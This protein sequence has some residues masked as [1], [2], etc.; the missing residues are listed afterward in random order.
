MPHGV[1]AVI[2]QPLDRLKGDWFGPC[3]GDHGIARWQL[4]GSLGEFGEGDI[5]GVGD[6]LA[7]RIDPWP[8]IEEGTKLERWPCHA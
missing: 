4:V 1:S 3:D 6:R 7:G 2:D 5:N 8:R